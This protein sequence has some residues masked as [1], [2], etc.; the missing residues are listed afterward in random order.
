MLH[1]WATQGNVFSHTDCNDVMMDLG[2]RKGKVHIYMLP[3]DPS[4]HKPDMT[5]TSDVTPMLKPVLKAL[6]QNYSPVCSEYIIEYNRNFLTCFQ[7]PINTFL[8]MKMICG[9]LRVNSKL[10]LKMMMMQYGHLLMVKTY[11]EFLLYVI[12]FFPFL[13]LI[14]QNC[15]RWMVPH[16]QL[17]CLPIQI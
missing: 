6:A 10:L 3:K 11:Y 14:F 13:I 4:A 17:W 9:L 1:G 16:M 15:D 7:I 8:S 12:F 2:P 5:V